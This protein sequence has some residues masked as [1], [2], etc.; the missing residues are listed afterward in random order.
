MNSILMHFMLSYRVLLV[1]IVIVLINIFGNPHIG[2]A[3]ASLT[4]FMQLSAIY[5][6][7]NV[8]KFRRIF[9]LGLFVNLALFFG[10]FNDYIVVIFLVFSIGINFFL[11][12]NIYKMCKD[13]GVELSDLEYSL[14]PLLIW[15]K[16]KFLKEEINRH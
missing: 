10:V 14:F 6:L 5:F 3:L 16:Y 13:L 11:F 7:S 2:L 9:I 12:R 15:R 4:L 8:D 1:W